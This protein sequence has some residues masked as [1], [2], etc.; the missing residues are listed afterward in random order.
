MSYVLLEDGT[1]F[2]GEAVRRAR[3]V[4]GEVVFNTAMS[5]YQES[6]TDP[7]YAGQLIAFTYPHIGNYGVSAP[8]MESERIHARGGDHARRAQPR[9]RRRAPRAAGSTGWPTAVCPRSPASTPA[10]S[11]CHIREARRDARR[12]LPADCVA[13]AK[14]ARADRGRAVDGRPRPRARGDARGAVHAGGDRRLAAG[15]RS[16]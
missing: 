6:M 13:E 2:D 5:G 12:D 1:R 14:R 15:R 16:R 7:S 8:A 11:C 4:T 3:P 10:R 9:R